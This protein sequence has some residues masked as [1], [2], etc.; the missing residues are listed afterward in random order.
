M[1]II[2]AS[3]NE[4]VTLTATYGV[5]GVALVTTSYKVRCVGDAVNVYN[6]LDLYES[7]SNNKAVV[8]HANIKDRFGYDAQGNVV[9]K[10]VKTTYDDT[11]LVK[12]GHNNKI[13]I[14]LD[15]KNNV[16]G[17][18]YE[19]NANN[20][21]GVDET[22]N[23]KG[24]FKEGPLN[25]VGC[26]DA[27]N[28]SLISVKGQDNVV[29]AIYEN[30]CLN[31]VQLKGCDLTAEADV[32]YNLK[33][34]NYSGTTVEVFGDNVS[35]IN[36]RISNG[37][38]VLRIFG[39]IDDSTKVINVNIS[40]SVLSTAREFIIRMGSNCFIEGTKDNYAPLID[41]EIKQFPVYPQYSKMTAQQ[42]ADYDK[43]YIKT[44]VNIKDTAFGNSGIFAIGI[45]SHFAGYYLNDGKNSTL[46]NGSAILKQFLQYWEGL[47][48]TSYG[49][50]LTFEGDVRIYDW[51]DI[52]K[53]DSSTLIDIH[54]SVE[55]NS[56]YAFLSEMR[57]DIQIMVKSLVDKESLAYK[58]EYKNILFE[59]DG[60]KYVHGG[61]A[62]FGGGKNYG[63]FEMKDYNFYALNG[64]KIRLFD[65]GRGDLESAAG[66]EAFYFLMH[67]ATTFNFTPAK[68][69][70]ILASGEAY[71]FV[72]PTK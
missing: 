38:T 56:N 34:L 49:A 53:V 23:P 55:G 35:I 13:K 69:D 70:E 12:A 21:A 29:F 50:K 58:E 45:D 15:I 61:I 33:D 32:T 46:A 10:E 27:N 7:T 41:N 25:F 24:L 42:K 66:E 8:L 3:L 14:L 5:N 16:Y 1:K 60:K 51:K 26:G 9:Y 11:Y 63:T 17:N 20:I 68:Q 59:Y 44:F 52:E 4:I 67:D 22:G 19:I 18:G 72:Y 40:N 2:D 65:A 31:N 37:R 57:L 54:E 48:K 71:N 28:S 62:F 30:V 64:Y 43:K 6:Y 36:S 47:A 39:D